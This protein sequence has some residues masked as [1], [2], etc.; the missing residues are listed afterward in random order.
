MPTHI[1]W[2]VRISRSTGMPVYGLRNHSHT[3]FE[4]PTEVSCVDLRGFLPVQVFVP[5]ASHW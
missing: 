3:Q 1:G 4:R 2:L 5:P